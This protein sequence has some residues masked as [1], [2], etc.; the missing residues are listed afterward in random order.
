MSVSFFE[1]IKRALDHLQINL[2]RVS[3]ELLANVGIISLGHQYGPP[4]FE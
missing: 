1:G 3:S 2:R 4:N